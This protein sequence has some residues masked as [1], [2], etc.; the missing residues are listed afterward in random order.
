VT[1]INHVQI[2]APTGCESAG[3]VFFGGGRWF[4]VGARRLYIG[5]EQDFQPAGTAHYASDPWGNR[6]EFTQPTSN[7]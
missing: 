7:F 2:A 4:R 1:D 6:L 3:R 5:V